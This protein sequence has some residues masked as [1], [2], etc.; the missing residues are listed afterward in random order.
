[1]LKAVLSDIYTLGNCQK[2]I[3]LLQRVDFICSTAILL[4]KLYKLACNW[5]GRHC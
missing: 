4:H 1:M 2:S 3:I 5:Y